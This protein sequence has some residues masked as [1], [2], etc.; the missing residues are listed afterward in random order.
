MIDPISL[1]IGAGSAL[2]LWVGARLLKRKPKEW[3]VVSVLNDDPN[4]TRYWNAAK[5]V[6]PISPGGDFVIKGG[7]HYDYG[8]KYDH[9]QIRYVVGS[10]PGKAWEEF[11]AE[12]KMKQLEAKFPEL[13]AS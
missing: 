5:T 6:D 2:T 4:Y 3:R 12:E 13:K 7:P 10:P 9:L 11:L 1:A 8:W